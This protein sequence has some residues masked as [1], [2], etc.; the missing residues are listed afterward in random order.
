MVTTPTVIRPRGKSQR[1]GSIA[2]GHLLLSIG[3][4]VAGVVTL[5]GCTQQRQTVA[6]RP[7]SARVVVVAPA[8]NLSNDSSI[9]AL[10]LTDVVAAELTSVGGVAVIP[11]NRVLA[12]LLQQGRSVIDTP[13]DALALA[14]DFGAEATV[15]AA[16]THY[17]AY[18]PPKLGVI[19]QWYGDRPRRM[20]GLDPVAA[21]RLASDVLPVET[22][23]ASP[24]VQ[25]Q[26]HYD[27]AEEDLLEAIE[28]YGEE[29]EGHRSP[30]GWRRYVV[31][32]ELFV[33]YCISDAIRTMLT[34]EALARETSRASEAQP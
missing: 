5:P 32:Q 14:R 20:D 18:D 27:A 13:E 28:N 7:I 16:I 26:R 24:H 22:A 10:K 30:Y 15:V 17:D 29:R 31:S 6:V 21:S 4:L 25:I 9:D 3:L 1:R 34:Q 8:L 19:L 2:R 33:R 23:G 12:R 11:V